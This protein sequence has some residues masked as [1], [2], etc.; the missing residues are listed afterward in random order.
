MSCPAQCG[1]GLEPLCALLGWHWT[2]TK[3]KTMGLS[4][5]ALGREDRGTRAA[6]NTWVVVLPPPPPL[7]EVSTPSPCQEFG[8]GAS[9][10]QPHQPSG[11]W[12]SLTSCLPFPGTSKSHSHPCGEDKHS[13]GQQDR[14]SDLSLCAGHWRGHP[15]S[16]G[17]SL[18]TELGRVWS[19]S[20]KLRELGGSW[21]KG[22]SGEIIALLCS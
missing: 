7:M 10:C 8:G 9:C 2:Q 5:A 13:P 14:D 19:T 3:T 11:H 20:P 4:C 1:P 22:G 15:S 17:V 16:P 12:A 18:G 6:A 21:R